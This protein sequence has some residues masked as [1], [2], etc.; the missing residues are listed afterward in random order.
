MQFTGCL[1]DGRVEQL[2]IQGGGHTWPGGLQYARPLIVGLASRQIDA[3]E[4]IADFFLAMPP[5]R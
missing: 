2:V 4:R 3:S 5:K 1:L